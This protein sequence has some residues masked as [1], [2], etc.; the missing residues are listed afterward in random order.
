MEKMKWIKQVLVDA[1]ADEV[2]HLEYAN[3]EELGAAIDMIKDMSK[4]IYNCAV[5]EA[6]NTA[7]EHNN[8][9][10]SIKQTYITQKKSNADSS[11][12]VSTLDKYVTELS[13]D[14]TEMMANATPEEKTMLKQKISSLAVKL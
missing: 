10:G 12:T 11:T 13:K 8:S 2:G 9:C 4:A 6:M 3:W 7:E 5:V 1:V 14:I